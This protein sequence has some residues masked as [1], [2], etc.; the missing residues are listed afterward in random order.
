M[1]AISRSLPALGRILLAVIFLQGG[2]RKL[3]AVG[4]TA[5][6]MANHGVPYSDILV[7]GAIILEL[8]GGIM[9]TVG[10]FARWAALAFFFYTLVLALIFHHFWTLNGAAFAAE[11]TA[12]FE[13]LSLMGGLLFVVA[14]GP[15][16]YSLDG[17]AA[18]AGQA[19]RAV[20]A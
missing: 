2:I 15:G 13:H 4:A 7:W 14:F 12:F 17:R 20:P 18:R 9:L 1:D 8:G 10:L 6:N 11:R 16:A 3:I 5:A 19:P